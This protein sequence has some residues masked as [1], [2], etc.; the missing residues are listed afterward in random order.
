M[1]APTDS[2][3]GDFLGLPR[4]TWGRIVGVVCALVGLIVFLAGVGIGRSDTSAAFAL[5][6]TGG[7]A[8]ILGYIIIWAAKQPAWPHP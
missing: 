6:V 4:R 5:I 3:V 2:H 1:A 8:E 7:T